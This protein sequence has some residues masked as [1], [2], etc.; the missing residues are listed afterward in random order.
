MSACPADPICM[1]TSKKNSVYLSWDKYFIALAEK[2]AGIQ[3]MRY[4]YIS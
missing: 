4:I 1:R 3:N 2:I